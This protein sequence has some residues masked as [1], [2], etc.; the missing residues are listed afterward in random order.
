MIAYVVHRFP[1]GTQTFTYDEVRGLRDA[2]LPLVV[3]SLRPGEELGWD[4]SGLV[5]KMLPGLGSPATVAAVAWWALRR[6]LALTR[7]SAFA[8]VAALGAGSVRTRVA[9]LAA[10]PRGALL[11]RDA[12]V[13]GFHAQFANE[14]ATTALV[15][16]TLARRPFSFRSHSAPPPPLLRRKLRAA[17][18]VLSISE[19]DRTS[20]LAVEPGAR[21]EV[22][23]L[24]VVVPPLA[25]V[26]RAPDL[27]VAVGSLIEKKGHHVLIEACRELI[28]AGRQLR[29]QIVGEGPARAGLERQIREAGLD[30]AV[31][32]LGF[33]TR[34][35]VGALL[36][37][38]SV[39]VLASV[40]SASEG[41]DGLPVSLLEALARA[42]PCVS[43]TI[44]AIPEIVLTGETG[45]LVPPG[46]AAALATAIGE[47]LGEPAR[48]R[49]LGLQGRALV[50]RQH[51]PATCAGQAAALLRRASETRAPQR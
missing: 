6:P 4:L 51:D 3:V 13:T 28:E 32:L 33:R 36:E 48:A 46:D 49:A 29:C 1:V 45:V 12:A 15:A 26:P 27:V 22:S 38:A 11:A 20:L 47:L 34:A 5:L 30:G 10:L 43:T 39:C 35:E 25:E 17:A 41:E 14:T 18:V 50:I 19:F 37:Q 44:S 31:E 42:T 21:V 24:G 8:V 16:A 23:R 9:E 40:P 2:G 7:C